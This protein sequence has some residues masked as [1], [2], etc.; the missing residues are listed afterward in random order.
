MVTY[1]L[2]IVAIGWGLLAGEKISFQQILCLG[3]ILA[4][5]YIVNKAK[6]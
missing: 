3:V 2:P 5:V 4:G 6:R 1:A